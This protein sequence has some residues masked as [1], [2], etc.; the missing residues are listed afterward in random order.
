[1]TKT[2][3]GFTLIELLVVIAIIAILAAILFPVFA[4]AKEAA[5]AT[6]ELSNAREIGIAYKLYINDSDDTMPIFYA[7]NSV[8]P[9]GAAGHKGTE[10]LLLTYTKN[11]QIFQS[12]LDTGGPYLAV[13][14]GLVAAGGS[15]TTYWQAYGTSFRFDHCMFTTAA[16]ESSQNN[17]LYDTTTVVNESSVAYPA[18]TRT[19]RL[20]MFP[21]FAL[22][23]DPGCARYGY[24]C[25]GGSYY[26]QW[27]STGGSM[28]FSD[29]HAKYISSNGA[30]DN[31]MVDPDGHKS[32]DPSNDPNAWSGTWYS[33]CD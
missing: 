18:Q 15:Y 11:K 7:Y 29:S 1:V 10:Q 28:I 12:P 19:I 4:K 26:R 22:A 9:S 30:F 20:E 16:N 27:G 13:D 3:N 23:Q 2:R 25:P 8:P 5:K 17:L 31:A 33:L 24:D 6:A 21:F 14:P 32:G